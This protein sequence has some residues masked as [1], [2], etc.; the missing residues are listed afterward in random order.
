[1]MKNKS[2]N[3]ASC[4]LSR[5]STDIKTPRQRLKNLGVMVKVVSDVANRRVSAEVGKFV[6]DQITALDDRAEQQGVQDPIAV[7]L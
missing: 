3:D 1:M 4:Y 2:I 6:I 5:L 7:A